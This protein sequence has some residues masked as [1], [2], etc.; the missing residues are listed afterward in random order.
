MLGTFQRVQSHKKLCLFACMLIYLDMMVRFQLMIKIGKKT[1]KRLCTSGMNRVHRSGCSLIIADRK[2]CSAS[3]CSL[4]SFSP[5]CPVG[6]IF[7]LPLQWG[8]T[9]VVDTWICGLCH[10]C[11]VEQHWTCKLYS[12][13][14]PQQ[15]LQ[16]KSFSEWNEQRQK[17]GDGD[18]YF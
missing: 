10:S 1:G 17:R 6:A 13:P 5:C 15:W 16:N 18:I 2:S 11:R 7:S 14:F 8:S 3:Q 12:F 9:G 4:G